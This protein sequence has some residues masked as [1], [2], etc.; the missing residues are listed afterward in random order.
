MSRTC[1]SG[2]ETAWS[3]PGLRLGDRAYPVAR[4]RILGWQRQQSHAVVGAV[5]EVLTGKECGEAED[6][7][8]GEGCGVCRRGR[9]VVVLRGGQHGGTAP[10]HHEAGRI[11]DDPAGGDPSFRFQCG[12]PRRAGTYRQTLFYCCKLHCVVV[13]RRAPIVI[14]FSKLIVALI[15]LSD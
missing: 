6:A 11:P 12:S 5:G 8:V 2:S 9:T 1:G 7:L 14:I 13:N 15:G 4:G 3:A 10:K